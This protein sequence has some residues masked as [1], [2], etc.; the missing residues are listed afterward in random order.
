MDRVRRR[1]QS[2]ALG[3]K[4]SESGRIPGV[5]LQVIVCRVTHAVRSSGENFVN[6]EGTLPL[7][8]EFVLFLLW[9]A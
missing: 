9:Q 6:D 7:G 1:T 3:I 4:S 8:L 2:S 5:R